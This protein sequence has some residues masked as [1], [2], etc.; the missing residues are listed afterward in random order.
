METDVEMSEGGSNTF[1]ELDR[2]EGGDE[3][4]EGVDEAKMGVGNPIKESHADV[5][6][7]VSS[8]PSDTDEEKED[9]KF[10]A[11]RKDKKDVE[12][13]TGS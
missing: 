13:S 5:D 8:W 3:E 12:L 11:V 9:A 6:S 7:D 1:T 10:L 4:K 2:V